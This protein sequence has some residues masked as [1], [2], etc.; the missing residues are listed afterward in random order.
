MADNHSYLGDGVYVNIDEFGTVEI[1]IGDHRSKPVAYLDEYV[2]P[3]LL[4]YVKT[5]EKELKK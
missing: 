1:R 4:E 2:L 5:H 3:K